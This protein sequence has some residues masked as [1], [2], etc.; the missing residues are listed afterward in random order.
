MPMRRDD[1]ERALRHIAPQIPGHEFGAVIDHALGSPGLRGSVP[2]TALWLS[3]TAYIRHVF[4]DY[5]DLLKDGYDVD[6]ARHF[7]RDDMNA[8]LAE[9]GVRRRVGDRD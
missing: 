9:W 5:D 2:E 8:K 4:T 6:S 3:M 7:V 1:L